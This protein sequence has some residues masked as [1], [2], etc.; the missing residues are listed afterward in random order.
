MLSPAPGLIS[1]TGI[2]S[3]CLTNGIAFTLC[4]CLDMCLQV[5]HEVDGGLVSLKTWKK[6]IKCISVK[7]PHA[8]M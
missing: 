3:P 5:L 6:R 7:P 1:V 2:Q 4:S 8:V